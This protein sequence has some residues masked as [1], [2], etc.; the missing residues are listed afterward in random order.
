ME[1]LSDIYW[2]V[3]RLRDCI[4]GQL[5]LCILI[6]FKFQSQKS[7]R[8]RTSTYRFCIGLLFSEQKVRTNCATMVWRLCFKQSWE[9]CFSS[10]NSSFWSLGLNWHQNCWKQSDWFCKTFWQ[11]ISGAFKCL[12]LDC[13]CFGN[14]KDIIL[15]SKQLIHKDLYQYSLQ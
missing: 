7:W 1:S 5:L 12:F 4:A 14:F 15:N 3:H 8:Q 6:K 9:S 10:S 13:F 2:Q 11:L